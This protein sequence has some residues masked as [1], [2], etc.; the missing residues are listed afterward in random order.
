M[1]GKQAEY[2]FSEMQKKFEKFKECIKELAPKIELDNNKAFKGYS[3]T[4]EF[5]LKKNYLILIM[6]IY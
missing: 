3:E 5:F 2:N 6:E 1:I 4:L